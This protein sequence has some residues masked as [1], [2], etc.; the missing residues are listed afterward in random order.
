MRNSSG[1]ASTTRLRTGPIAVDALVHTESTGEWSYLSFP[2]LE[3]KGSRTLVLDARKAVPIEVETPKPSEVR[4]ATL[5]YTR[6]TPDN[7]LLELAAYP[8]PGAD[9]VVRASVLPTQGKVSHG[10]YEFTSTARAYQPGVPTKDSEYVYN[11][12]FE[13]RGGVSADQR[14]VVTDGQLGSVEETW[15]TQGADHV[16]YDTVQTVNP[17]TGSLA[18]IGRGQAEITA[19]GSRTAYFQAGRQARSLVTSRVSSPRSSTAA[20]RR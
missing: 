9:G 2:E 20:C 13:E 8:A 11:L 1:V 10:R 3:L 16:Y 12:A 4:D 7:W 17:L 15:Y 6:I 5:A 19:P 14:H 18:F